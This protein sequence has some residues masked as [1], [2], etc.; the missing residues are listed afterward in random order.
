MADLLR[1]ALE[2]ALYGS[3][4]ASVCE[5]LKKV[6]SSSDAHWILNGA[7]VPFACAPEGHRR[8]LTDMD[9]VA[10][11]LHLVIRCQLH[12][13]K[14]RN[15]M[16]RLLLISGADPNQGMQMPEFRGIDMLPIE[17]AGILGRHDNVKTLLK[18]GAQVPQDSADLMIVL[19]VRGFSTHRNL[20]CVKELLQLNPAP[21]ALYEAVMKSVE[22]DEVDC[23]K[24]LVDTI[25]IDQV[26]AEDFDK[27]LLMYAQSPQVVKVLL[28]AEA[29]LF[30]EDSNGVD[31][32]THARNNLRYGVAK[33]LQSAIEKELQD[34]PPLAA[35]C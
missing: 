9:A 6:R 33:Q 7:Q 2:F 16:L 28:E 15:Q 20:E 30:L 26:H 10:T 23:V 34:I 18:F 1:G 27:T 21:M 25:D 14:L 24:A 11:P 13:D 29:N 19:C 8:L 5:T 32:L 17:A 3:D 31:A 12:C 4:L 22:I 35:V